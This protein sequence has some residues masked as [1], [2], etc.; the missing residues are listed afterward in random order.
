MK[1]EVNNTNTTGSVKF[2]QDPSINYEVAGSLAPHT[3]TIDK[4]VECPSCKRMFV[5]NFDNDEK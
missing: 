1:Y 2:D 5:L 4:P 3:K